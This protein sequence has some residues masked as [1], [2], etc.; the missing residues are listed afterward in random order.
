MVGTLLR[1]RSALHGCGFWLQCFL[2]ILNSDVWAWAPG[3]NS[4]SEVSLCERF[5]DLPLEKMALIWAST[6]SIAEG[7]VSRE[8]MASLF[9]IVLC[10]TRLMLNSCTGASLGLCHSMLRHTASHTTRLPTVGAQYESLYPSTV[11]LAH[12]RGPQ[13]L[14]TVSVWAGYVPTPYHGKIHACYFFSFAVLYPLFPREV[15]LSAEPAGSKPAVYSPGL[16]RP[17]TKTCIGAAGCKSYR[18]RTPSSPCFPLKRFAFLIL[19]LSPSAK[20]ST[21]GF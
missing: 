3:W 5:F 14:E 8:Q 1:V 7:L 20:S 21:P 13:R 12:A 17:G 16:H 18:E 19:P 10:V 15:F 6:V 9:C 4:F 11:R 2:L